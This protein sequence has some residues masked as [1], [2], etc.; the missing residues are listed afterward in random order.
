MFVIKY[1]DV[2]GV[3]GN[4]LEKISYK[5][6][7]FTPYSHPTSF[8]MTERKEMCRNYRGNIANAMKLMELVIFVARYGTVVE[9]SA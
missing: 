3:I 4:E 1:D 6:S 8:D 9:E 5:F 7:H 2:L